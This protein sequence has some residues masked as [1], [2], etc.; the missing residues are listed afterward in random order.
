SGPP[1]SVA[2]RPATPFVYGFLGD[3]NLFHSRIQK[4]LA[5]I[6]G[7]EIPVPEYAETKDAP[8][9]AFVRPHQIDVDP[10]SNGK[11]GIEVAVRYLRNL[12]PIV[13]LELTSPET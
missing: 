6:G 7:V 5:R 12:G 2:L 11:G 3:V 13:R 9:V 4:G 10:N 1:K 8:A